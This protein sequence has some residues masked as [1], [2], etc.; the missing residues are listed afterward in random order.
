MNDTISLHSVENGKSADK[1]SAESTISGFRIRGPT[2]VQ[3]AE[4]LKRDFSA[5]INN[6]S[7]QINSPSTDINVPNAKINAPK[8]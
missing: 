1:I 6:P 4:T 8:S 3:Q 5:E 7:I 2:H